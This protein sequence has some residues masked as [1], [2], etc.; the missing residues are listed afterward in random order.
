[1][2]DA[3]GMAGLCRAVPLLVCPLLLLGCFD[4]HLNDGD[5]GPPRSDAGPP[6]GLDAGSPTRRDAGDP[7]PPPPLDAGAP[8]CPPHRAF[9]GC[10]PAPGLVAV[11]GVPFEVPYRMDECGCCAGTECAVTS[12]DAGRRRLHLLTTLCPDPCDC[13]DCNPVEGVCAIPGLPAAGDW[14]V[15]INDAPAVTLPVRD[16]EGGPANPAGCAAF[17]EDDGCDTEGDELIPNPW[18]PT[19]VC[20]R[21]RFG[22]QVIELSD[23]CW[24]CEYQGP[25]LTY[26]QPGSVGGRLHLGAHRFSGPCDGACDTVC[27]EEVR[28][29]EIPVLPEGDGLYEVVVDGEVRATLGRGAQA[30]ST[31][32]C[33]DG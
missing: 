8:V 25:C 20:V 19:S 28:H 15:W 29:C 23:D 2:R 1:M 21:E 33:T 3:S 5:A 17:A 11:Q 9:A 12:I 10:S 32:Y 30:S 13:A 26:F 14:Q 24:G 31:T 27:H 16:A 22:R 6:S 7:P 4:T 18:A